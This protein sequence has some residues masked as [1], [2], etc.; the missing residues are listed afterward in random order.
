MGKQQANDDLKA[1]LGHAVESANTFAKNV[2]D[3]RRKNRDLA[4][5]LARHE[6]NERHRKLIADRKAAGERREHERQAREDLSKGIIHL[7][8]FEG[9]RLVFTYDAS[10][11]EAEITLVLTEQQAK[12]LNAYATKDREDEN[13]YRSVFDEM[14]QKFVLRYL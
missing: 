14:Q 9:T 10:G 3:L 6:D 11:P 2:D 5:K 1:Q 8:R 4:W 7:D 12:I 13:P